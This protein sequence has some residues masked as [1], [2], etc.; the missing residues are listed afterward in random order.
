MQRVVPVAVKGMPFQMET[1]HLR[2]ADLL[3]E[4][5]GLGIQDGSH[6]Q[7]ARGGGRTD[8]IHHGFEV[9]RVAPSSSN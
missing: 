7:T 2:I 1:P 6:L 8:H 5:V 3:A 4:L 9:R